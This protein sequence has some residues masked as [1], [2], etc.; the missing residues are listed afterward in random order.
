[1]TEHYT[2]GTSRRF[3][4]YPDYMRKL[5][6]TRVQKVAIDAGFTCP[7]RDGT[8]GWGGCTY[9][10][11]DAFNPSYCSASKTI[12]EQ[13][14]EGIEFH[15]RR[16]RRVL[17]YIAYFQAYTNTY[18]SLAELDRMYSE[19]LAVEGITGLIIGTR[20]D[21]INDQ[22][23]D[24][25]AG[26]AEK[27]Y[28][29]I[30]YGIESVYNKTLERVNRCHTF[31]EAVTAL[32]KTAARHIRAGGHFIFG[33]PGETR[34]EMLNSIALISQLPLNAVK[35]HQL[36]IFKGTAMAT[37]FQSHPENFS[38]FNDLDEYLEFITDC[39]ENLNPAFVV[40]RIAGEAPPR[41]CEGIAWDLRNDQ[42]LV[43][44]EKLLEKK[45]TWQGKNWPGNND[46]GS[47]QPKTT[48]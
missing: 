13:V 45:N 46:M 8:K 27:T 3:N 10:I 33:L 43:K 28:L 6:G 17:K 26:L 18:K 9:C 35:F 20:P 21:A 12:S 41:Y 39:I 24:Y 15:R 36:Q 47:Q 16:Y 34:D 29:V 14:I 25:F 31:E 38:L 11:N 5:F 7:N 48:R 40:E 42:I 4:A 22:M 2:W 30:E 37:E 32:E 23:L 19:A 1:M 44:F